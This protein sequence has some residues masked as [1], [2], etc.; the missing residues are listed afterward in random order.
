VNIA[1][2]LR[3]EGADTPNCTETQ[4][5]LL[6]PARK[7]SAGVSAVMPAPVPSAPYLKTVVPDEIMLFQFSAL[8]FNSHRIHIDREHARQVEGFPD[9][10]VNGGLVTLLLTEFIR[11]DVGLTPRTVSIK[12]LAP[13]FCNRKITLAAEPCAQHWV[14]R[15][16][17]DDNQLAA[18]MEVQV[19]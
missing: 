4:T 3:Q 16:Y 19:S 10:V 15:A 5:Y 1:H 18:E 11:C 13:L 8:G 17:A 9:L 12:H 6:M 2:E 14:V 7:A